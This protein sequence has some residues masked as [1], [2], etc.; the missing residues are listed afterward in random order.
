MYTVHAHVHINIYVRV[1]MYEWSGVRWALARNGSS[2]KY[3]T[4]DTDC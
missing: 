4:I 3:Q 1:L 2:K